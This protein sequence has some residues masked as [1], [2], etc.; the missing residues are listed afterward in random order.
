MF[1]RLKFW[2][3]KPQLLARQVFVNEPLPQAKL[4]K[5]GRPKQK[6][7]SN[8]ITTS[9]YNIFTFVPK[10]L[11][12]QFRRIANFFFL[13]LVVLQWFPEFAT[14]EPVVAALPMFIIL[15]ITAI[16]DGFED[17]KRHVTDRS[18]NDRKIWTLGNWKNVNYAGESSNRFIDFITSLF[19][20]KVVNTSKPVQKKGSEKGPEWKKTLV[21][22]V[23]VGDFI[24]LYND[25]F[26]PAGRLNSQCTF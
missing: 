25:D 14:I 9:K 18:V 10:N 15:G 17:F 8:K 19:S 24:K 5:H 16:K 6:Y 26:I 2:R 3:R 20:K 23:R 1:N 22:N 11:Y 21:K 7:S 13:L 4:D 12:E